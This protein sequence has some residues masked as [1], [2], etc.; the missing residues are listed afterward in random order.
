MS[1]SSE[2]IPSSLLSPKQHFLIHFG[3]KETTAFSFKSN[4]FSKL[5]AVHYF[6]IKLEE[7]IH[8]QL[9]KKQMFYSEMVFSIV[10]KAIMFLTQ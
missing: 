2:I 9:K 8:F 4:I 6:K 7:K 3:S 10:F 1:V 5:Q